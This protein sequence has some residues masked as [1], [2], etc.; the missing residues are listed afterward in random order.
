MQVLGAQA[1]EA[2]MP[3]QRCIDVVA[4][5][6]RA[7]SR[8]EVLAPLR[9]VMPLG[10]ANAMGIMPGAMLAQGCFGVKVLALYPGNGARGL[11]SHAGVVV[12]FDARDGVP[13]AVLESN[14][15]T[16][17]R[18]AAASAVA[19]RA[20]ARPGGEVLALLGAGHQ[21]LWHA[22]ALAHVMPL[23]RLQ[24]WSRSRASAD[25]FAQGLDLPGH[26]GCSA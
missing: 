8:G 24:V 6:M 12:L 7:V 13:V 1:I 20:L 9:S 5:A 22:R 26:R 18:T 16:A 17:L 25:R 15:L 21:A 4:D 11:P 19:T 2:L 3:I 14:S 23:R 10:A